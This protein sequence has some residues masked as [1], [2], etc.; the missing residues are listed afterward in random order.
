MHTQLRKPSTHAYK[1]GWQTWLFPVEVGRRGF[2][3][4]LV[5]SI[6][7]CLPIVGKKRRAAMTA[8]TQAAKRASSWLLL[9]RDQENLVLSN[10]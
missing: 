8:I 2:P 9:K 10:V 4:Q 6:L 1:R 7:C 5:W 3:V